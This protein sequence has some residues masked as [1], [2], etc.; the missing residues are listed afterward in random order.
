MKYFAIEMAK[1]FTYYLVLEHVEKK[2]ITKRFPR[3]SG[4]MPNWPTG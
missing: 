2:D 3:P 4:T 1:D